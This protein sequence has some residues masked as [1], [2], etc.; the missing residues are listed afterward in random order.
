[1]KHSLLKALPLLGMALATTPA[2]AGGW[3]IG[4]DYSGTSSGGPGWGHVD[5]KMNWGYGGWSGD[6]GEVQGSLTS[7]FG[8]GQTQSGTCAGHFTLVLHYYPSSATDTIP[9]VVGVNVQQAMSAWGGRKDVSKNTYY[10]P[11]QGTPGSV[12]LSAQVTSPDGTSYSAPVQTTKDAFGFE[13]NALAQFPASV[14]TISTKDAT[15]QNGVYTLRHDLPAVKGTFSATMGDFWSDDVEGIDWVSAGLSTR[16]N[17]ALDPHQLYISSGIEKSWKKFT[18]SVDSLPDTYKRRD[19]TGAVIN[20]P[21]D[22]AVL[23]YED[24]TDSTKNIWKIAC[25]RNPDS[26]MT[27][28]SLANLQGDRTNGQEVNKQWWAT[29][30]A[31]CQMTANT[32]GFSDPDWQWSYTGGTY[33]SQYSSGATPFGTRDRAFQSIGIASKGVGPDMDNYGMTGF[34]LGTDPKSLSVT[35]TAFTVTVRENDPAKPA[36]ILNNSYT[37]DWH[38]PMEG[39]ANIGP[40]QPLPSISAPLKNAGDNHIEA[41][42]SYSFLTNKQEI[43][44]GKALS[45]GGTV[46]GGAEGAYYLIAGT[47]LTGPAVPLLIFASALLTTGSVVAGS[48]P[49]HKDIQV[50]SSPTSPTSY[51]NYKAAVLAQDTQ[52]NYPDNTPRFSPPEAIVDAKAAFKD[53]MFTDGGNPNNN[54]NFARNYVFVSGTVLMDKTRETW[55]CDE[56]GA[57]GYNGPNI[58]HFNRTTAPYFRIKFSA[59]SYTPSPSPTTTPG[60]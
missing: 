16:V 35:S 43:D 24:S 28:E 6:D 49:A 55:Q 45:V 41:V 14:I 58:G 22:D 40:T 29:P 50:P 5:N 19:S 52:G 48:P 46:V 57:N 23:V 10:Y 44:Y 32:T 9:P 34:N 18:G 37:V 3:T 15:Q 54:D 7:N 26:S 36:T 27:V 51:A 20:Q 13:Y 30:P 2:W 56:Y 17:Y 38:T 59:D 21:N 39:W 12:T 25:Q 8:A 31:F 1:M 42:L 33:K 11:W 53:Q 47:E 60:G 4:L